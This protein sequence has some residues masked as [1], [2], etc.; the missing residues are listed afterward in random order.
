MYYLAEAFPFVKRLRLPLSRDQFMLLMAAINLA[1]L[2][3]DIYLAHDLDRTIKPFEWIPIVFAPVAAVL[4]LIAGLL[5]IRN[6][7]LANSIATLVFF[8]CIGIG[9]LGSLFHLRYA[10]LVDAPAGQ[11][12]STNVLIWAPP[13]LGPLTFI[14]IA[15]L[16][17][18]AAWVEDPIDSG[19]LTLLSNRRLN[20][21]LSK[22]RA[23]FFMVALFI[24]ATVVSSVLDH[25]RTGFANPWLWLPTFA[26]VFAIAV[27]WAMGVLTR[28]ERSDLYTYIFTML[29]LVV[30]G[31]VGAWLHVNHNLTGQGAV[32]SERF[33]RGAPFLAP[34]LF[35]NMGAL[36]IIVLLD[37]KA[38]KRG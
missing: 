26:G 6:R 20:M 8:S 21:P 11:Q 28:L 35:A 24:L 37:P 9:G 25:A 18:S 2:G 34:L 12:I 30:V 16:G 15:I 23:Y 27:T 7:P 5:A 1:F 33:L 38:E 14:L 31:L 36:G 10:L 3:V 32:I 13:L 17:I 19:A 29:L 4:L 22:T